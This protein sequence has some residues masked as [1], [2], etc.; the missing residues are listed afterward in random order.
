M[1][2]IIEKLSNYEDLLPA[3]VNFQTYDGRNYKLGRDQSTCHV[4]L[5]NPNGLLALKSM[6]QLTIVESYLKGDIDFEGDLISIMSFQNFLL[7][8]HPIIKTWRKLKPKLLGR[9]ACNP[10]WIEKHYD[11]DNL[12]LY[13]TDQMYYSYTP[14][15]YHDD[16]DSLEKGTKR[17]F[18][19]ALKSLNV[20]A[21][22][23]VLEI[24]CGWGG[25]LRY[26]SD[27]GINV[28]GITLSKNQFSFVENTI[29]EGKISG[30]VYYQDF[31]N[32]QPKQ[33]YDGISLMGAIEDLS[34]Y[35]EVIKRIRKWIKPGGRIYL[36]FASADSPDS[37]SSFI[38]KYIWPGTFR[39]VYMPDFMSAIVNSPFEIIE[40]LNDKHNYHLWTKKMLQ[41]WKEKKQEI[42][43]ISSEIQW[44][45]WAVLFAG[46]SS[47][48]S[49]RDHCTT[50][51]RLALEMP[52]Q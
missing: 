11:S 48:M 5:K 21:G 41:R 31:F 34:D 44:R 2:H 43:T 16:D 17:K 32:F 20:K 23:H 4:Y 40:I 49:R 14:G 6:D 3:S 7:D 25:F 37:T 30:K 19:A 29:Q 26:C 27:H 10:A 24:G 47:I 35:G 22:D 52:L 28:E 12:Q 18:E 46:V 39:M 50:A 38:T 42:V 51:F 13:C 8:K 15:I 1:E 45:M 33:I 9:A 36:D